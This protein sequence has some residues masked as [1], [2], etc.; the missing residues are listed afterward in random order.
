LPTEIATHRVYHP[1]GFPETSMRPFAYLLVSVVAVAACGENPATTVDA[2]GPD[3]G[4]LP[5]CADNVDNDGDGYVDF[6]NDPGC[7]VPHVDDEGDACPS[8]A[9]CPQCGDDIDND[10]NGKTDFPDD[11][12][13]CTSAADPIEFTDDPVACGAGMAIKPLPM[14]GND[15][16]G[17]V[18]S[19]SNITSPCGGGN[20]L[21]A[22]A[23][24]FH[25][26]TPRVMIATTDDSVTVIDTVLDLRSSMCAVPTSEVACHDDLVP[27]GTGMN[28]KSRL[29]KSLAAGTYY[30]IVGGKTTADT[31]M[32]AV[33]VKFLAGEGAACGNAD[34]CGPG[35]VCRVPVNAT[36]MVC[37]KP[38]CSDGLDDDTDGIID[39]PNDPGCITDEDDSENDVCNTNPQDPACPECANG[40]DDNNN[41]DTD[42]PAESNCTSAGSTSE[43][44]VQAEPVGVISG[45]MTMGTT[46]GAKNDY[47]PTCGGTN[48]AGDVV[49]RLDL[50]TPMATLNLEVVGFDSA[51]ALLSSTCENPAIA[52]SDPPLMTR[53]NVAAG[54]YYVVV[55]GWGGT[56]GSFTLNTSGTIAGG[57]SCEGPL[58]QAGAFTCA[59]GFT[60][61]GAPGSKI[62]TAGAC[63]DGLDN[64]AD[65]KADIADPGCTG[66]ADNDETDDCSPTVGPNCPQ[67][68]DTVDNDGD[69]KTDY[70]TDTSCQ[71]ASSNSEAC[72]QT[73]PIGVITQ[74]IT[75]GTT[76]GMTND[77]TPSCASSS[78]TAPDLAYRLDVPAMATLNLD[79]SG[80]DGAHALLNNTCGGTAI[81]CS[82]PNLMTRTNVAAGT[83]YVVV[84]AWSSGS[85]PFTLTTSGTV[86]V[87]AS[88]EGALFQSGAF[89]CT[90]GY[91]CGG[92]PGSR[93]C[94]LAACN[95]TTDNDGD[96]KV[97]VNDPGCASAS[98]GDETDDC[99]PTIG[100]NCPKCADTVDND[101]D[102]LTDHPADTGCLRAS[103]NNESCPQ[104]EATVTLT[105][106]QTMGTTV[107]AT[108]D[109]RPSCASSTNTAPDVTYR[110][111][112]P[113]LTSLTITNTQAWDGAVALYNSTCGG[114]AL[115][116]G[117]IPEKVTLSNVSAGIYYYMV[118]GWST[119]SGTFTITVAGTIQS[120]ASCE[121]A[122]AQSGALVCPAQHSC[123]GPVGMR[124]CLGSFACNDGTDND[125]DGKTD[126]PLEPGCTSPSDND[127][128]DNCVAMGP[129][130]PQCGNGLD[131]DLDMKADYPADTRCPN[132][133]FFHEQ[134]CTPEVFGDLAG[135]ITTPTT[136]DTLVGRGAN[137]QQS[138]QSSTG[139]DVAYALVLPVAVDKLEIDT[140]GSPGDTVISLWN[141]ACASEIECDDDGGGQLKSRIKRNNVAAGT[142]AI[143]VD[144]HSATA[145]NTTF[146]LNVKGTVASGAACTDPLF[147]S[148]VLVC[149][150]GTSCTA[151]TCQ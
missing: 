98:D 78:H 130:C 137:Y 31:G 1:R 133:S 123:A 20:G 59:A 99:Y 45:P 108:H 18:G 32:Y 35:L 101:M 80:F 58:V 75:T 151:G 118:D 60:C 36:Q 96:G 25:L 76:A 16:G 4:P 94:I 100:P 145:N 132:A 27:T 48:T 102:G 85:G 49:Y 70:P 103:S 119:G 114:T 39:W 8:G 15:T 129:D 105:M 64:D 54:V 65:G 62:C 124:R 3:T 95:D 11:S 83:Y 10:G 46:V 33:N 139:N 14:N 125:G 122:L 56:T 2:A 128:S 72:S 68:S 53:T 7:A 6:P 127:E 135:P 41:G 21:P 115:G 50:P 17:L 90:S 77:Y 52:C 34:D 92:T 141:A 143:Q 66:G 136:M 51:H 113:A 91:A 73:E 9:G 63:N 57:Q 71:R 87:G 81:A 131:D 84:D 5:A 12:V 104:T 142:Y 107:G 38:V 55:D 112:L 109:G 88:C 30:L 147:T 121:S 150:T 67:C 97:D 126:F 116:C 138:C 44:C 23:Y 22:I 144:C 117:D 82:D 93:T 74:A 148:G 29:V 149:P 40:V 24:V 86:A 19:T 120:G 79:L 140:L 134:F 37:A 28:K 89:T 61:A 110:L 43:S 69:G 47:K 111:D 106:P 42:Y 13:G 26:S 146:Q